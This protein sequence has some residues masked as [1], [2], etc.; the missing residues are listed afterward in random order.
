MRIRPLLL[1][2]AFVLVACQAKEIDTKVL[3]DPLDDPWVAGLDTEGGAAAEAKLE[4]T[5]SELAGAVEAGVPTEAGAVEAGVP[6]EVA[7]PTAVPGE[8]APVADAAQPG[9][10]TN[11]ATASKSAGTPSNT[12]PATP[13]EPTPTEA[14]VADPTPE[15]ANIQPAPEAQPTPAQ[16]TQPPPITLADF[17]GTYRYS[18]GNAQREALDAAIEDAVLQLN[19]AI[20]G[21]G[22][23]RLLKTNPIDDTLQIVVTGDKVQTIFSVSGFDAEVTLGAA[24]V[25]YTGKSGSHYKVRVVQ[26]GS[27]LVQVI[28]GEDGTKTTVFVLS[29]DRSKLTV[30]HKITSDRLTTPMTYKLSFTRK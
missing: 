21:I 12:Q 13:G 28:A 7:D 29:S 17:H 3:D 16:P 27:K 23:K 30:N 6:T 8:A 9:A 25:G 22:R 2:S 10:P 5:P 20:R 26:Q 19:V 18:G 11:S 15:P 4:P 24:A 1:V 14:P